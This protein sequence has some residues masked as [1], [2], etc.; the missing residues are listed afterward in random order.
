MRLAAAFLLSIVWTSE[1][2]ACSCPQESIE[3]A[4]DE[5]PIVF[6]AHV[7][8]VRF[9]AMPSSGD[10]SPEDFAPQR[11]K[12]SV[13]EK[14]KGDPAQVK[15][16][17]AGYGGGD[18]GV[19]LV[20]GFDYMVLVDSN[21]YINYCSGFFGPQYDWKNATRQSKQRDALRTFT[22]S[23]VAH[24]KTRGK[25]SRPPSADLQME[26]SS[27]LWFLPDVVKEALKRGKASSKGCPDSGGGS[28]K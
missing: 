2:N 13:V 22:Q 14:F 15:E 17:K 7:T 19:P 24:F 3:Q 28:K 18:C 20:V 11:A 8:E 10:I 5:A 16:L 9:Q 4:F 6:V 27:T 21:G 26:D 25:I 12:F 1:V 23:V